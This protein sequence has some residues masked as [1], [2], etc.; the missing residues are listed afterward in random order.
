MPRITRSTPDGAP[1]RFS[2]TVHDGPRVPARFWRLI[3]LTWPSGGTASLVYAA[4]PADPSEL[5]EVMWQLQVAAGLHGF[6][7]EV[8]DP[9]GTTIPA[10]AIGRAS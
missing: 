10:P 7:V 9:D 3:R 1:R 8:V 2:A 6:E 5:P 4:E